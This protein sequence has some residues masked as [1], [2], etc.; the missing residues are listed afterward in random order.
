MQSICSL[1]TLQGAL[2]NLPLCIGTYLPEVLKIPS[3]MY[4]CKHCLNKDGAQY[5][6]H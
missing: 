5:K 6:Q 4:Y 2:Q 3:D 1:Q